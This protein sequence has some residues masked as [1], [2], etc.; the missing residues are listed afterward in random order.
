MIRS[1]TNCN[2]KLFIEEMN[3]L[4]EDWVGYRFERMAVCDDKGVV[5]LGIKRSVNPS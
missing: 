5:A 2:F 3:V 4:I 1:E